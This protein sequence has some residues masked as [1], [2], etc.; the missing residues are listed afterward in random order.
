MARGGDEVPGTATIRDAGTTAFNVTRIS[1]DA[2]RWERALDALS[3]RERRQVDAAL[4]KFIVNPGLPGLNYEKLESRPELDLR[5]IRASKELRILMMI[6]GESVVLIEAGHHDD[7]YRRSRTL[8]AVID[9]ATHRISLIDYLERQAV[10][11]PPALPPASFEEPP[12]PLLAE[13]TSADLVSMGMSPEE[14]EIALAAV[15]LDALMASEL[16]ESALEFAFD[17]VQQ[18]PEEWRQATLDPADRARERLREA[19]E[20]YGVLSGF[21]PFLDPA[22][23]VEV[24]RRPIEDWMIFLHPSQLEIATASFAGPARIRGGPGTGKTVLALHRAAHLGRLFPPE[25]GQPR[26]LFTTFIKSLATIL[27]SLFERIPGAP[28]DAVEFTT[29]SSVAYRI[30]KEAGFPHWVDEKR[31]DATFQEFWPL[32]GELDRALSRSGLGERYVR[33]EIARVIK[34]RGIERL[35]DYLAL[36]RRGR[37]TPLSGELRRDIWALHEAWTGR[38]RSLGLVDYPDVALGALHHIERTGQRRYDAVI[39]D[40]AQDLTL[41]EASLVARLSDPAATSRNPESLL[42]AG[43]GSQRF[44]AG[45]YRLRD[46]GIDVQGRS[47]A[48]H[49]NYRNTYETLVTALMLVGDRRVTDLEEEYQQGQVLQFAP[50]VGARPALIECEDPE[51]E[52][53]RLVESMQDI[54]RQGRVALGDIAVALASNRL[55]RGVVRQLGDRGI[56]AI[57]LDEYDGRPTPKVKVGTFQRLKG[58]EF[59]VVCLPYMSAGAYPPEWVGS[60]ASPERDE[61]LA[62]SLMNLFIAVT[63][64][65]DWVV[66]TCSGGPSEILEPV[67]DQLD[68]L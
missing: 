63:R 41:V 66:F 31:V 4:Q 53:D 37:E 49:L 6:F 10:S 60:D 36:E 65:R 39:V 64:A 34:G 55:V 48:L 14:A 59:K 52:L 22:E 18:T 56:P 51:D 15:D 20:R 28:R 47:R 62:M 42:I 44:Y 61:H 1:L 9:R 2:A 21:T 67:I 26:I 35:E 24:A 5:T 19:I 38:N 58:L 8:G 40:E 25:E 11:K 32:F 46:A 57:R 54:T 7:I 45:G 17:A 50:R 43:D 33:D 3:D 29:V 68:I 12:P 13:W 16:R 27:A 23:A 30:C